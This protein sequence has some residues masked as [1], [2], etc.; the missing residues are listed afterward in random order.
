MALMIIAH[1]QAS[2]QVPISQGGTINDM[3][4]AEQINLTD[5]NADNGNYL[6]GE[7]HT[8]TLCVVDGAITNA[9]FIISP[10]IYDHIWD[11]DENSSLFIYD[12]PA[13]TPGT[14]VGEFN[15]A[16]HP[17]GIFFTASG[18]CI[19]FTFVSGPTSSGAGFTSL[20]QCLQPLQPFE[21]SAM[22]TPPIEPWGDLPL[23]SIRICLGDTI[24]AQAIT[25]YPLSDAGGN[26]YLQDDETS[27][28]RWD[29]GDGTTFLGQGLTEITHVYENPFGYEV[30]LIVTDTQS[31]QAIYRFFVLIAP[32]P[33]FSN[34][35]IDDTLCSN[36]QTQITGGILGNDTVGITPSTSAILG[37]AAFGQPVFLPDG[38]DTNYET[39]III[40]DFEE[41]QV[42]EDV[43]D[44]ISLCVNMEHSYL[45]D[46]EMTLTCPDG[47][48]VAIFNTF[49]GTGMLPPGCAGGGTFLGDANDVGP[50][51]VPGIGF[52]YCFAEDAE[53][54]TMCEELAAGNTVPVNTFQNGNAMAPGTYS[55][56]DS[57]EAF[58]GCPIN[59][60][61]TLTVRDNL[62][63]DDGWIF[64]WSIYFNP[65]VNPETVFFT[66]GIAEV[67]WEDNED[68]VSNEGTSIIVAPSQ[69][70][71]NDFTFVAIDE[72]GCIHDTTVFVYVR[73]EVVAEDAIACDLTHTLVAQNAP[74]DGQWTTIETPNATAQVTFETLGSGAANVEVTYHGIY[75]FEIVEFNCNYRDTAFVDFRPDPQIIPFPSDT[76]LCV[77]ASIVFDAGP[78]LP[79]SSNFFLAWTFNGNVVDTTSYTLEAD[80]TGQYQMT[81]QGVCGSVSSSSDVV[82]IQLDFE[83]DTLCGREVVA[84]EATLSPEG[85]GFWSSEE[86]GITFSNPNGL[87][88]SIES[89]LF[90][91]FEVVFTDSRCPNDGV[92]R[93]FRFVQQPD[94]T[95]T[96]MFPNFCVDSD[97]LL[98]TANMAGNHDGIF[99]WSVDGS[100]QSTSFESEIGFPPMF[101][102]PLETYVIKVLGR[103]NFGVCPPAEF[104]ISF[105]GVWCEYTIPNVVTPNGDQRNDTWDIEFI[106]NFPGAGV[107]VYNRWGNLIFEQ[108]NYD[109]FQKNRGGRGW[110]PQDYNQGVYFY[111][112]TLPSI[113]RV[114]SGNLSI[115]KDHQ[116]RR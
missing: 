92:G 7:S 43:T 34:L 105:E 79:N 77:G 88:T 80:Q 30:T 18:T 115:L 25:N 95:I 107:R 28:F 8:I 39:T 108:D 38:N 67:Y 104:G 59:G 65:D 11:I 75:A 110:D 32:R 83:G 35:A 90:G 46:L 47:T 89:E 93:L 36:T 98:L 23:P 101:F 68:I 22:G 82:A 24:S 113:Q 33:V 53:W 58:V 48:T 62:F 16:S 49:A 66:P 106:E 20:F 73:P 10:D 13:A 111:E 55:P 45:G 100:N 85:S 31:S 6:P 12:G 42:I 1:G 14:L 56:E 64:S 69:P 19:T 61:W 91:E 21:V 109:Q 72:F 37:G 103:D 57:F 15:T 81:I 86:P 17:S 87:A 116:P 114:E 99:L 3:T 50:P 97:S 54:G 60:E 5:S 26:G 70:G 74:A 44:I 94:V 4:C 51:G 71:N 2:A 29:M 40:E 9:Q 52:D 41:G 96:P 102:D 63:I 27:T 84:L 112:V 78:Q 76:V